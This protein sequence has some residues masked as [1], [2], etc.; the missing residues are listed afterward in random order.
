M[1]IIKPK[2]NYF[3]DYYDGVAGM[4]VDQTLH[5]MRDARTVETDIILPGGGLEVIGFCGQLYPL[6]HW[7]PVE[8]GYMVSPR[9][10]HIFAHS[11]DEYKLN[12]EWDRGGFRRSDEVAEFFTRFNNVKEDK[13]FVDIVEAPV[14]VLKAAKRNAPNWRGYYA[15]ATTNICLADYEFYKHV[16]AFTA[17]QTLSQ[18]ISNQLVKEKKVDVIADKYR[19]AGHG[20]DK[21]S[22]RNPTR[23]KDLK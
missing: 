20:F 4:G 22:F 17:F 12:R 13:I 14:F 9:D 2:G 10:T 11:L 23:L 3:K 15:D 18:Y 19:I 1:K 21:F 6:V 16:D 5:Y 8:A 7:Y